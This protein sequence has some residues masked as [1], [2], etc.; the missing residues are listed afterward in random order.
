MGET[1]S[2]FSTLNLVQGYINFELDDKIVVDNLLSSK[3]KKKDFTN[4]KGI[5][6]HCRELF[7][8]YYKDSNGKFYSKTIN[9]IIHSLAET[10]TFVTNFHIII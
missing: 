3:K 7:S 2:L 10:I 4:F 5:T 1:L 6:G 8:I 9:R